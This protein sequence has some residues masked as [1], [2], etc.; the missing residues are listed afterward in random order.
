MLNK[1]LA[2]QCNARCQN[3]QDRAYN[4]QKL[5]YFNKLLKYISSTI[6]QEVYICKYLPFNYSQKIHIPV[7]SIFMLS[8]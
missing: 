2:S 6:S 7:Q 4:I 8:G 1:I 3:M 5:E